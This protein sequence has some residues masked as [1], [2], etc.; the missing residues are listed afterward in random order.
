MEKGGRKPAENLHLS[1]THKLD[2]PSKA[3]VTTCC[4]EPHLT[5]LVCHSKSHLTARLLQWPYT[6]WPPQKLETTLRKLVQY[7]FSYMNG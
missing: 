3:L 1:L 7:N 5:T 6:P 4:S 2:V